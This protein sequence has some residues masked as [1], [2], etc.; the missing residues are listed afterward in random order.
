MKPRIKRTFGISSVLPWV[1]PALAAAIGAGCGGAG[2]PNAAQGES[3]FIDARIRRLTSAEFDRSVAALLGTKQELGAGFAFDVRQNGFSANAEQRVDS[4]LAGQIASAAE[5]LAA[6]AVSS[7]LAHFVPCSPEPD[8]QACAAQFIEAFGARAFRRPLE[9]AEKDALLAVYDVGREGG[10]FE[11]GVRLVVAAVL[12]SA[13]FLYITELGAE[14]KDGIV[15]LTPSEVAS[16]LAYFLTGGPPDEE[17]V[18]AASSGDLAS[19]QAREREARR[20]L[21]QPG[22]RAQVRRFIEEWLGVIDIERTGKS[23]AVYPEFDALRPSMKAETDAFIDD[24]VWSGDGEV[25]TLLGADYTMADGALASFYGVTSGGADEPA[26]VS[27][28]GTGRRGILTHASFL[29]TFGRAIESAPVK[30]GVV[31]LKRVLCEEL[32][33]P[34][35]LKDPIMPPAPDPTRTTRE[36]FEAHSADPGCHACHKMID[37][38]GFAFESFDGMGGRRETENGKPV[39]T[40]SVLE[41]TEIDGPIEGAA[42]LAQK[43]ADSEAALRCF[44]RNAFRFGSAQAGQ[45]TEEAFLA[46]WEEQPPEIRS[47]VVETLVAFVKSDLFVTRK[48]P[49]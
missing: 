1:V 6:E 49:Q 5:A 25:S 34:P 3:A 27:L 22:A 43:I 33:A 15:T 18:A 24:V 7:N 4:V 39:D 8:E 30:R 10:A 29:A 36:R 13:S 37:P 23:P 11:D 41:G 35:M 32:G 26:R 44:A 47:N 42:D 31:V 12:Q 16:T 9:A 46:F 19:A 17:L 20:L 45:E 2:D 14:V 38:I 48:V 21:Q 40:K 28:E